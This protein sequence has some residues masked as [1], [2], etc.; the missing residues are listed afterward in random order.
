MLCCLHQD[1]EMMFIIYNYPST[2]GRPLRSE[3]TVRSHNGPLLRSETTVRSHNCLTFDQHYEVST[4]WVLRLT[5]VQSIAVPL[6]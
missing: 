2:T 6:H 1:I 5:S 4:N 3:T